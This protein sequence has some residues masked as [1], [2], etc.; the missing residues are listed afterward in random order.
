MKVCRAHQPGILS[1]FPDI[2]PGT[3][4]EFCIGHPI[5]R[6]RPCST[7]R[8]RNYKCLN[9]D[10]LGNR[11]T[12]TS[13]HDYHKL[14]VCKQVSS[15]S[16]NGQKKT[17]DT[18]LEM[19]QVTILQHPHE[20]FV[21]SREIMPSFLFLLLDCRSGFLVFETSDFLCCGLFKRFLHYLYRTD[22]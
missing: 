13:F 9:T 12:I 16:I 2:S 15:L 10:T 21:Q 7:G 3:H 14:K 20:Q 17:C 6:H 8:C 11:R 5:F 1:L 22:L 19:S 4:R 18:C